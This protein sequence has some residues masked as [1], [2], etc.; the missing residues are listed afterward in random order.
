[1][2]TA[3][4]H[5]LLLALAFAPAACISRPVNAVGPESAPV[6]EP[7]YHKVTVSGWLSAKAHVQSI[8]HDYVN[9]LLRAQLE[10]R[11]LT[12]MAH[13]VEYQFTWLDGDGIQVGSTSTHWSPLT[14][15]AGQSRQVVQF[16]PTQL[17][18]DFKFE[19]RGRR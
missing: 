11:N 10:V 7:S 8:R 3:M 15:E 4:L 18:R 13:K 6:N 1:M 12:P 16:A 19:V 9:G 14:L 5:S 2:K 17:A